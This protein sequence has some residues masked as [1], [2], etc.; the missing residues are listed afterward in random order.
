[1]VLEAVG[2]CVQEQVGGWEFGPT[3][4]PVELL[5]GDEQAGPE[6]YMVEV[7]C[8]FEFVDVRGSR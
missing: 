2:Q 7:T 1:M 4:I 8:F 6:A 5:S 3:D